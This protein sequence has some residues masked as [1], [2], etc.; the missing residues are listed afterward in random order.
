VTK[1]GKRSKRSGND[2][3][4]TVIATDPPPRRRRVGWIEAA[5]ALSGTVGDGQARLLLPAGGRQAGAAV[6]FAEFE[7][8]LDAM[9]DTAKI[10]RSLIY[11]QSIFGEEARV[12]VVQMREIHL[13]WGRT[14]WV[15]LL[16][17]QK[18][19]LTPER[20]MAYFKRVFRSLSAEPIR[21]AVEIWGQE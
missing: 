20:A 12:R 7:G 5:L 14:A 3:E 9:E 11:F 15:G 16:R 13:P 19:V 10:A 17:L 18:S 2:W 6:A 21:I 4:L 1:S 8:E